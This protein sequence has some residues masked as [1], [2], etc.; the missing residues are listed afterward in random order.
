MVVLSFSVLKDKVLSGEKTRTMRAVS[1]NGHP[2]KK[3][4]A[5]YTKWTNHQRDDPMDHKPLVI[6]LQV[7]WKAR[8]PAHEKLFDA[9]LVNITR[10]ELGGLSLEEWQKDG[11]ATTL[12][13]LN[14][15]AKTYF[16]HFDPRDENDWA[17]VAAFEVY[18]IEFWRVPE[19][20]RW[21]GPRLQLL[22]EGSVKADVNLTAMPKTPAEVH[23]LAHN[24]AEVNHVAKMDGVVIAAE[25][26]MLDEHPKLK[27]PPAF[28]PSSLPA[29]ADD[30][31][32][33]LLAEITRCCDY[34]EEVCPDTC[35]CIRCEEDEC[36]KGTC[37]HPEFKCVPECGSFKKGKCEGT[38]KDCDP[39]CI[40]WEPEGG[41]S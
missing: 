28:T 25:P 9:K 22:D 21:V 8:S 27:G 18:I 36:G 23:Q 40:A 30:V 31:F 41:C 33:N 34:D 35:P 38:G 26:W 15:F 24:I 5:V 13:G 11:F 19:S 17:H 3:W 16:K 37:P 6:P 7:Y 39:N 32:P 2:N 10:R 1:I 4:A 29:Y 20:K 12:D 14:W